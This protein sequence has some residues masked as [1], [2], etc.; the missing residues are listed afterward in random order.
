MDVDVDRLNKMNADL[1]ALLKDGLVA[2]DTWDR[3]TGLSLAGIESNPQATALFNR[4]TDEVGMTLT[5]SGFPG[6]GRYYLFELEDNTV[7]A[8]LKYGG[9]LMSGMLLSASR[10]NL[11]ILLS[12]G[13][14]MMM[15]GAAEACR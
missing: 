1:K 2:M 5:G 12:V 9:D 3:E 14:P 8:I 4:M 13:I 11:G 6:L 15:K 10:V 7:V